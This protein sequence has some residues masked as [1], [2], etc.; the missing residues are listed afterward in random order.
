M[1]SALSLSPIEVMEQ[2]LRWSG[3]R[4]HWVEHVLPPRFNDGVYRIDALP[5]PLL[6]C[7]QVPGKPLELLVSTTAWVPTAF[8]TAAFAE[9]ISDLLSVCPAYPMARVQLPDAPALAERPGTRD[10]SSL[11]AVMA[12]SALDLEA[13]AQLAHATGIWMSECAECIRSA[14]RF[15]VQ[16]GSM[17]RNAMTSS[18]FNTWRI[19]TFDPH[20][21]TIGVGGRRLHLAAGQPTGTVRDLTTFYLG[22]ILSP[23]W[24]AKRAPAIQIIGVDYGRCRVRVQLGRGHSPKEYWIDLANR[25]VEP[26]GKL[27]SARDRAR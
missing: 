2:S 24:R 15:T 26:N 6:P 21:N 11:E 3:L 14:Q 20:T 4:W 17:A 1:S 9:E 19:N 16:E 8:E 12:Q 7:H 25:R 18:S 10:L 22:D 23:I 5:P 27:R 13:V